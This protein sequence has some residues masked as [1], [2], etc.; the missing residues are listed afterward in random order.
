MKIHAYNKI[1]LK[2]RP[3]LRPPRFIYLRP[4]SLD[5]MDGGLTW[6]IDIL[7]QSNTFPF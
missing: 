7:L 2:Y 1:S 3:K 6:I 5:Q 4:F